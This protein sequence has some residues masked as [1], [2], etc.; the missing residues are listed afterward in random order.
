MCTYDLAMERLPE[1]FF[2][3]LGLEL[4]AR[5]NVNLTPI[6]HGHLSANTTDV[7]LDRLSTQAKPNNTPSETT[8]ITTSDNAK[9]DSQ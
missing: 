4:I 6:H 3:L 8:I 2:D 7:L 9:S 1:D 5:E